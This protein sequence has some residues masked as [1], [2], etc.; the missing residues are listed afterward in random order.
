MG[1]IG[2]AAGR[3][4]GAWTA[5][6]L[7]TT[8]PDAITV[9][10][11]DDGGRTLDT[12]AERPHRLV[13]GAYDRADGDTL[14]LRERTTVELG[15][16]PLVLPPADRDPALLLVNDQDL[17]YATVRPDPASLRS[18]LDLAPGLPTPLARTLAIAT[19]WDLLVTGELPAAD[20]VDAATLTLRRESADSVLENLLAATV[21]AATWWAPDADRSRLLAQVSQTCLDLA[22]QDPARA[23]PVL[24]ALART[25]DAG[26]L[27]RLRALAGDDVD[28]TWRALT[29]AGALGLLAGPA[30]GLEEVRAL[31]ERD[32]D[33]DVWVRVLTVDAARPDAAGKEA[34]WVAA[35]EQRTVPSGSMVALGQAFWQLGQEEL[36]APYARRFLAALPAAG[37]SGMLAGLGLV[38]GM[39]PRV[40]AGADVLDEAEA[41]ARSGELS[42]LTAARALE[43]VDA[44][45][46][47][48]VARAAG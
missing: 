9:T 28:L 26:Q 12:G 42:P 34:A 18:L 43:Q 1:A 23:T 37:R 17:T 3:D 31:R 40:A 8:G 10:T 29:R 20:Y 15:D 25:A 39:F 5:A 19:L 41:L 16:G 45:R 30:E 36:L 33:P 46:R 22:E 11:G 4:L 35:V 21:D 38:R 44:M 32:P 2:A 24:R 6:W 27:D 13:L 7:D 14:V 48:A 47:M